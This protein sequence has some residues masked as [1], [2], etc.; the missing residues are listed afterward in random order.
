[1][2]EAGPDITAELEAEMDLLPHLQGDIQHEDE[3]IEREC[4]DAR[5]IKTAAEAMG[6]IPT[7]TQA[8]HMVISG[9]FALW[10]LVPAVLELAGGP[11]ITSLHIATLGFSRNNIA[12]LCQLL[13]AGRIGAVKLLAS[14]YFKGTSGGIYD[15]AVA[16][17]DQRK[18]KA[19]FLSV[20]THAKLLLMHLSD[21]RTV[22]IESSA[23]LRSCQNI[24]QMTVLGDPHLYQF[25][26]AWID[27]LFA[28]SAAKT[29]QQ[30]KQS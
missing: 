27:D 22:T 24:E 7:A 15:F 1:M 29:T 18:D 8:I 9:R 23:N 21:N 13:D 5:K 16:E 30:E 19:K 10:D 14:H 28:R 11:I 3:G 2:P 6:H 12:D 4:R 26:T 20:R 25:H 17:L